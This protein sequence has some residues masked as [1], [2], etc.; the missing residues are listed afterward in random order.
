MYAFGEAS[1][2]HA[3]FNHKW[4]IA[5]TGEGIDLNMNNGFIPEISL[6]YLS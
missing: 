5:S 1:H 3:M 6:L 2:G 4:I